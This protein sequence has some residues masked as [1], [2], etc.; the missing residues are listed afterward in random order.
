MKYVELVEKTL[1][2]KADN[3]YNCICPECGEPATSAER[4]RDGN[5]GCDNGHTFNRNDNSGELVETSLSNIAKQRAA[6]N[7]K[8][9]KGEISDLTDVARRVKRLMDKKD[10]G[11]NFEVAAKQ[12]IKDIKKVDIKRLEVFMDLYKG[13]Y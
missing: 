6:F 10:M 7:K 1:S 11:F 8:L 13:E 5:C 4:R 2:A 12:A 3:P 9:K